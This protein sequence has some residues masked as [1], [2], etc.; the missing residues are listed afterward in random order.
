MTDG[1]DSSVL[2]DP[3]DLSEPYDLSDRSDM[4]Y[5]PIGLYLYLK[6]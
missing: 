4:P 1:S 2:S 3:S 6:N 5:L